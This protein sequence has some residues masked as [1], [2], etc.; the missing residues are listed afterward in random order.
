MMQFALAK[1]D[2]D[3][4]NKLEICEAIIQASTEQGPVLWQAELL[5]EN[6]YDWA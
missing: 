6:D 4:D 5:L 2:H 1:Q 3:S